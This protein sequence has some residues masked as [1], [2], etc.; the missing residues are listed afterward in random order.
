MSDRA[1]VPSSHAK[2]LQGSGRTV[3][4]LNALGLVL[5]VFLMRPGAPL[6]PLDDRLAFLAA[7]P[8]GW[9]LGWGVWLLAALALVRFFWHLLRDSV[10]RERHANLARLALGLVLLGAAVDVSCD[11]LQIVLLPEAAAEALRTQD[12]ASFQFLERALWGGG[13]I[14]GCGLY[15]SATLL[16]TA[17]RWGELL[18]IS[19]VSGL[20]TG[21]GGLLWVGAELAQARALLEPATALTVGAFVLWAATLTRRPAPLRPT[22][23]RPTPLRPTPRRPTPLRPT[24]LPAGL[25]AESSPSPG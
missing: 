10:T 6:V 3:A 21:L 13:V 25:D 8:L 9:T 5:A 18:W 7:A 16:T 17:S 22:P 4:G 24:P 19:R 12:S 15:C 11:V 20:G 14:C 2:E 1:G 23:L